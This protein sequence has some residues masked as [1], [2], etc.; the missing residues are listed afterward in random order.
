MQQINPTRA[1]LAAMRIAIATFVKTAE[2]SP[3]KTRLAAA[4]SRAFADRFYEL[5]CA[6]TLSV[7]QQA[8]QSLGMS[9]YW[10]LAEDAAMTEPR[11][12]SLPRCAQGSG[13]LG[14]RM[15]H[16]YESLR[17][18]YQAVYLIGADTP[19]ICLAD[20]HALQ[21]YAQAAG[22]SAHVVLAPSADGGFWCVG[23]NLDIADTVWHNTPY[24]QANTYTSFRAALQVYSAAPV[25]ALRELHDVDTLAD[26]HACAMQLRA[27]PEPTSAQRALMALELARHVA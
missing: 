21:K 1:K 22:N 19:Q 9:C 8:Q 4:S 10:A 11:W 5:A 3:V 16:V 6:A 27:L 15:Q 17:Q 14:A 24:S 12:Q 2:L 23:G 26:W 25:H 7:L 18:R 20:L 13:E